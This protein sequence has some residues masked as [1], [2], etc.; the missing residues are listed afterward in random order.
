M[1]FVPD[2]AHLVIGLV[3]SQLTGPDGAV[4]GRVA[5]VLEVGS[6]GGR[7]LATAP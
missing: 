3:N 6:V 4:G 1:F 5:G 7:T 2:L